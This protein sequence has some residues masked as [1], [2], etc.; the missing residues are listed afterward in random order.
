MSEATKPSP[1][2]GQEDE[3]KKTRQEEMRLLEEINVQRVLIGTSLDDA[4]DDSLVRRISHQKKLGKLE[5]QYQ[6]LV[7]QKRL[8]RE[9]SKFEEMYGAIYSEPCLICL[10]DIYVNASE[11]LIQKFFCCGG[12]I[13]E[14]C[15]EDV[16]EGSG[17]SKCP[18]CRESLHETSSAEPAA[19]LMALAKRGVAWAQHNV[20]KCVFEGI[21][22]FKKQ[23]KA[24]LEWINKAAAQ[25]YPSALY[26]LSQKNRDGLPS[27]I[28]K[29]QEK[30]NDLLL[31]AANLGH[32]SANSSLA[33]FYFNG[34]DGFGNEPKDLVEGFFRASIAFALNGSDSLFVGMYHNRQYMLEP[35]PYLACYYLNI[36][37]ANEN[38]GGVA[39]YFYSQ[40]LGRLSKH[41]HDGRFKNPGSNAVP[42]MFFWLR[43][44]RDLGDIDALEQLKKWETRE[45]SLCAHCSK[46]AQA[47]VKFKQCSK[48]KAQW[49]CSKE[50]QVEAWK[51]GHKKDCKRS[52]M[53]K[54]EDYLNAD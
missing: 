31:K 36:A 1:K 23:E 24:G 25:Q 34:I 10:E 21:N 4:S 35:S 38:V 2:A 15:A 41:L 11:E 8:S 46:K 5:F 53:L 43:K 45:Q 39:C 52:R 17:I 44:S 3:H 27:V 18:L 30:A 50:C 42:A 13:C 7:E 9:L 14:T 51:A 16:K 48:C 40:A 22:G 49:Y 33:N 32:S 54:F 19:Q 6:L 26:D 20:G 12:F 29:S 37:T 28:G 47:Q